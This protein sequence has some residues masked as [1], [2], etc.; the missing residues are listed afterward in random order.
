[1]TD[2]LLTVI[3]PVF[4]VERFLL[5]CLNSIF[6]QDYRPMEVIAV[7]DGSPD[8]SGKIG[9]EIALVHSGLT[10][11][12]QGNKWLGGARNTGMELANGEYT[13]F[14]DS[15]DFLLPSAYSKLIAFSQKNNCQFV[16]FG[17]YLT[18][19]DGS[20]KR[21]SIPGDLEPGKIYSQNEIRAHILPLLIRC[22]AINGAQFRLYRGITGT[23][24]RD[25]PQFR[26]RE[27][28][29]YAEDYVSCL[30]WFPKIQSYGLLPEPLYCYV[31]N[32]DSIMNAFNAKRIQQLITL[33]K[34]R[35][36]FML[37]EGLVSEE[38]R[39]NSAKLLMRL[40]WDQLLRLMTMHIPSPQKLSL[41][42]MFC[43]DATLHEACERLGWNQLTDWGRIGRL[44][45]ILLYK[46]N[47][48]LLFCLLKV[49]T[50]L[51]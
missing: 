49:Q 48:K 19:A 50:W 51:K 46:R 28:L 43:E 25:T 39:I 47:Y 42:K 30:D 40:V 14:V 10:V 9:D 13:S 16:Q 11:I 23:V 44:C 4:Q 33:Y 41:L 7:D 26:F 35:E 20:E 37:R 3:V 29:R 17:C 31:V 1:M 6:I 32:P 27:S 34:I 8:S 21:A 15:D 45:V 2:S 24:H 38:N 5:K 18:T 22:H 36:D 12:H